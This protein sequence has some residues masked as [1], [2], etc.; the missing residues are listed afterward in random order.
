MQCCISPNCVRVAKIYAFSRNDIKVVSYIEVNGAH[1]KVIGKIYNVL[2]FMGFCFPDSYA[3]SR[4]DIKVVSYIEVD[5]AHWKVIE[6]LHVKPWKGAAFINEANIMNGNKQFPYKDGPQFAFMDKIRLN[7]S[8][9][10]GKR[11]WLKEGMDYILLFWNGKAIDFDH[12]VTVKLTIVNVD[13]ERDRERLTMAEKFLGL[14]ACMRYEN[15][16]RDLSPQPHYLSMTKYPKGFSALQQNPE[17]SSM[18]KTSLLSAILLML[19][20]SRRQLSDSWVFKR[21]SLMLSITVHFHCHFV[22]EEKI[23]ET[24]EHVGFEAT[25]VKE[26]I[27]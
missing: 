20:L 6:F 11:K 13:H 4:N 17:V 18:V 10:G 25:L 21:L 9:V 27:D 16:S 8:D 3:F 2:N 26:E 12:P 23:R 14:A 7:E 1:W 22:D 15:F 19:D 5:G 24:I